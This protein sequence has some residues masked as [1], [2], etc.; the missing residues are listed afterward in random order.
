MLA[1]HVVGA[2]P[3]KEV[4]GYGRHEDML[5]RFSFKLQEKLAAQLQGVCLADCLSFR[6]KVILFTG[7]FLAKYWKRQCSKGPRFPNAGLG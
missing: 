4:T 6:A 7:Q 1:L 2:F 3:N 5:F